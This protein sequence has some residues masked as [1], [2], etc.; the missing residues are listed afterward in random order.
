MSP[1]KK[2]WEP[3]AKTQELSK[4]LYRAPEPKNIIPFI[5]L[6]SVICGLLIDLSAEG[7][8]YGFL[9]VGVPA[10]LS[11]W[12]STKC[13]EAFGGKFYF[14]RSFL[15]SLIGMMFIA[16]TLV[17][18]ILIRPWIDISW[19]LLVIYGYSLVLSM[20]YLVIRSTCLNYNRYS[21][22]ISSAQ[23]F[24]AF[25]IHFLLSLHD[26]GYLQENNF[27]SIYESSFGILSAFFIFL[28]SLLFIE[29]VNAPLKTD[30]GISGSDLLGFFLSYM[31]EGT[32]EIETLFM[33]LQ[34][35]FD[36]PFSV[37]A[38]RKKQSKKD[39]GGDPGGRVNESDTKEKPFYALIISPSIHPGPVGTIGGGDLPSKIA[40]PLMD[41]AD[42]IFVPHG[43]ATNDNNPA[44]TEECGKLVRAVRKLVGNITDADFSDM[45][46]ERFKLS[47]KTSIN[48]QRFGK[49]CLII[50]EPIPTPSDDIALEMFHNL[51]WAV[52]YHGLENLILIDAHNNSKHGGIPTH[53]GD[54]ISQQMEAFVDNLSRKEIDMYPFTMGFGMG[55]PTYD[56]NGLG[57]RGAQAQVMDINGSKLALVLFDGNNMESS[58]R[59]QLE[60]IVDDR[61]D[62]IIILT[63]DN[64]VVNATLGGYNPIGLRCTIDDLR[65]LLEKALDAAISDMTEC[66]A[67]IRVGRVEGINILG[68][69][70]TNRLVATINS[71]IAILK[72]AAIPCVLLAMFTTALLYS[73]IF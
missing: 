61:I 48:F 33:H 3:T 32:K 54:R 31:I 53:V 47:D 23:T 15:T 2:T 69:G 34:E 36:V 64:H 11:G 42:H 56:I 22:I 7:L 12:T 26:F 45:A 39:I 40:E 50:S 35:E 70:N 44:T 66:S 65:P 51:S 55:R 52:K 10:L 28:S 49:N 37:M 8:T 24:F 21:F 60:N 13:V 73:L 9:F 71:T 14:R 4:F 17:V 1:G 72:R 63:A 6:F 46:S 62:E 43:A 29:I 18:G 58:M 59:E 5:I 41:L 57:P 20:R 38:I 16:A 19:R 27:I 30:V 67:T 25:V 68:F